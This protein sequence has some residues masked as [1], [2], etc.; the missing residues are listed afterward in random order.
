MGL[1][2]SRSAARLVGSAHQHRSVK[3]AYAV[4]AVLSGT[5]L[6]EIE[7]PASYREAMAG[8][9][10][11]KWRMAAVAEFDGCVANKT[12]ILVKRSELPPGTNIL[13]VKWV[14][15]V[16]TDEFGA[17]LKYKARITPTGYKQL[18]GI[19]FFQTYADT[20]KYKTLRV[21]LSNAARRNRE[22]R[23][24]DV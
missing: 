19:D 3:G 13:P 24:L 4:F 6:L 20:G 15:K 1:R 14:F 12:W 16:K 23:Q 8:R 9:Q 11:E 10:K 21:V 18:H 2:S 7:T 5:A 17:I 22:L